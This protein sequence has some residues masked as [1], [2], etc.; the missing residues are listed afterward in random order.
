M[1]P[2][3]RSPT[4]TVCLSELFSGPLEEET[5]RSP[6]HPRPYIHDHRKSPDSRSIDCLPNETLG[7]IF[8]EGRTSGTR[9]S[10]LI[11]VSHVSRRWRDVAVYSPF[12]WNN[13]YYGPHQRSRNALMYTRA[14]L[15]RSRNCPLDVTLQFEDGE[16]GQFDAVPRLIVQM[17]LPHVN[18]WRTLDVHMHHHRSLAY[19]LDQLP[20]QATILKHVRVVLENKDDQ[21]YSREV[22][23]PGAPMLASIE[24]RG[25]SFASCKFPLAQLTSLVLTRSTRTLSPSEFRRVLTSPT[26]LRD[27]SLSGDLVSAGRDAWDPISLP[28]LTS[29][30]LSP[31]SETSFT[32]LCTALIMPALESLTMQHFSPETIRIFAGS[33]HSD[34]PKY[35]SLRRLELRT[36]GCFVA[37]NS[38]TAEIVDLLERCPMITQLSLISFYSSTYIP[39][40][41]LLF[42][43]QPA[44]MSKSPPREWQFDRDDSGDTLFGIQT[45][46]WS[47]SLDLAND[48]SNLSTRV[49][50]PLLRTFG[51][52]P[53]NGD[54][55]ADVCKLISTRTAA[56]LAISCFRTSAYDRISPDHFQWLREHVTL[57]R[58]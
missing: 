37:S 38:M 47:D 45:A 21:N 54:N 36:L 25:I 44:R 18:R 52:T 27:L 8:D 33:I 28:S 4:L 39:L 26:S 11:S 53:L 30:T 55:I 17:I 35:P 51:I 24:L 42:C 40:L 43:E 6:V 22:F 10:W 49:L 46:E 19:L 9:G 58:I 31:G 15:E 20:I 2:E 23:K 50:L 1:T 57:D 3:F 32:H 41:K 29:L 14:C 56:G 16:P 5:R 48:S 12:L 34:S 13:I 7:A